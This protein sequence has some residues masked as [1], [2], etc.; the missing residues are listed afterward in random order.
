M[1]SPPPTQCCTEV[2][3]RFYPQQQ[4]QHS[5]IFIHFSGCNLYL[6]V[7]RFDRTG[8]NAVWTHIR[9]GTTRVH[10]LLQFCDDVKPSSAMTWNILPRLNSLTGTRVHH[11]LL[12]LLQHLIR[13]QK[14]LLLS[15]LIM[16]LITR[17]L[18]DPQAG[19][20]CQCRSE[21][22]SKLS[23]INPARK[24]DILVINPGE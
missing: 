14:L 24:Y 13:L 1:F 9:T 22:W 19:I 16:G 21:W 8:S 18:S 17:F 6:K 5:V 4:F 3:L 23:C 11:T 20:S 10:S 7:D 15:P 12:S 2:W